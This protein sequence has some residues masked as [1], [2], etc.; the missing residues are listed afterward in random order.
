MERI[1]HIIGLSYERYGRPR[2]EVEAEIQQRYQKPAPPPPP[3][4][5]AAGP[6]L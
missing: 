5:L 4:P 1:E 2:D 6:R 3:H